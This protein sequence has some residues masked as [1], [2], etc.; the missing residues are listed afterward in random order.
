[1]PAGAQALATRAPVHPPIG[2]KCASR[3]FHRRMGAGNPYGRVLG[4]IGGSL[5]AVGALLSIGGSYPW[6]SLG[7]FVYGDDETAQAT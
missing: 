4:I 7:I 1:M 6:W 5:G 2:M 3:Q